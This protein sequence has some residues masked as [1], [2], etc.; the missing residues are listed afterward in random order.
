M[1]VTTL[2]RLR[3]HGPLG[4]VRFR[5]GHH[6]TWQTLTEALGNPGDVRAYRR[7]QRK[8][9]QLREQQLKREEE[10]RN[11]ELRQAKERW[12]AQQAA[13]E[14]AK[15]PDPVCQRCDGPLEGSPFDYDPMEEAAPPA[16]GHHCAGCRIQ[17]AE[18]GGRLGR[19][20]RRL[21]NGDDRYPRR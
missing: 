10:Q 5:F 7:R 20:I 15:E 12:A 8:R 6:P 13:A 11:R 18:P 2:D 14:A 1:L 21:A 9:D 19:L 16:D 17:L 4:S 3:E